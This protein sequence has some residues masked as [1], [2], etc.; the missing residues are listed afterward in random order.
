MFSRM[1]RQTFLFAVGL[2]VSA[3]VGWLLMDELE[4]K[5]LLVAEDN[6]E[7][8]L[9]PPTRSE[10]SV[11][12]DLTAINGIGPVYAQALHDAGVTTFA[13]LA[14]QDPDELAQRMHHKVSPERIRHEDWI[15]QA[16]QLNQKRLR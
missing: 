12:D 4:R 8:P 3:F 15:G 11:K 6:I 5:R 10:E 14:E 1:V 9:V 7:L 2:A 13:S 16:K